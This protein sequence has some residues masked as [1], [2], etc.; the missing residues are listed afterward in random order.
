MY[1]KSKLVHADL[2]PYNLLWFNGV[3]HFIDLSQAVLIDHPSALSYLYRYFSY[4]FLVGILIRTKLHHSPSIS[5]CK[6]LYI[7]QKEKKRIADSDFANICVSF[8]YS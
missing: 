8:L 4:V 3:L 1:G 6:F 7:Q 2:S 5:E